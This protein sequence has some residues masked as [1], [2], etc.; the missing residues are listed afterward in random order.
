MLFLFRT[1]QTLFNFLLLFYAALLQ[2]RSFFLPPLETASFQGLLSFPLIN[3]ADQQPVGAFFL[4][5]AL[6]FV[7]AFLINEIV[8]K[9]RISGEYNLLPGLFFILVSSILPEFIRLSPIHFI[10]ILL[11]LA[12]RE[13]YSTYRIGDAATRI[14][15]LGLLTGLASLFYFSSILFLVWAIAGLNIMRSLKLNEVFMLLSGFVIPY[16]FAGTWYFWYDNFAFFY[17]Q[18][19]LQAAGFL[20]WP[21]HPIYGLGF[22]LGCFAL[23][24]LLA[25]GGYSRFMLRKTNQ[26]SRKID[27][28]YL[29]MLVSAFTPFIQAGIGLSHLLLLG[30]PLGIFLSFTFEGI[31]SRWAEFIHF[32]ILVLM[33]LLHYRLFIFPF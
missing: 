24:V 11:L 6:L 33:L 4:R 19:F 7:E 18:Q 2:S 1:R 22:K 30:I 21:K 25:L 14:V 20:D 5:S 15:N 27:L 12:I 29:F 32:V 16:I 9:N 10:N 31:K 23:L 8:N 28:L 17:E 26:E 3:W 13:I